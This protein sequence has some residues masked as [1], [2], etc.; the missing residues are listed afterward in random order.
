MHVK[1]LIIA[2]ALMLASCGGC[3]TEGAKIIDEGSGDANEQ[4]L[5]PLREGY[6]QAL[7]YIGSVGARHTLRAKRERFG[8]EVYPFARPGKI[9]GTA[10]QRPNE[11]ATMTF[12]SKGVDGI[13]DHGHLR[14][15][16][17]PELLVPDTVRVGMK[18]TSRDGEREFEVIDRVVRPTSFGVLPVWTIRIFD[19]RQDKLIFGDQLQLGQWFDV[20]FVEGY[21]PDKY[22]GDFRGTPSDQVAYTIVPMEDR[23]TP[24]SKNSIPLEPLDGDIDA[25]ILIENMHAIET[26]PG[27]YELR[28]HGVGFGFMN[29]GGGVDGGFLFAGWSLAGKAYD[30]SSRTLSESESKFSHGL[31]ALADVNGEYS[32]ILTEGEMPRPVQDNCGANGTSNCYFQ[33]VGVLRS[34]D[35]VVDQI[36]VRPGYPLQP[37]LFLRRKANEERYIGD[38]FGAFGTSSVIVS[39]DDPSGGHTLIGARRD[40]LLVS[41]NWDETSIAAVSGQTEGTYGAVTKLDGR[42]FFDV[43]P[44]GRLARLKVEDGLI[45]RVVIGDLEVPEGHFVE[46]ALVIEDHILVLTNTGY[47]GSD[48]MID[49]SIPGYVRLEP[50]IRP[51]LGT[52]HF[53]TAKV[54]S[55]TTRG[56]HAAASVWVAP[57]QADM[58]V[59]WDPAFGEG[60]LEGWKLGGYPATAVRVGPR[61]E[62]VLLIRGPE[63]RGDR[64]SEGAYR[65]EG[66]IPGAGKV[67]I[68]VSTTW[69]DSGQRSW[70]SRS[71]Y[72]NGATT[73]EDGF[74]LS[75]GGRTGANGAPAAGFIADKGFQL[76]VSLS[77]EHTQFYQTGSEQCG[78]FTELVIQPD[79]TCCVRD[80]FELTDTCHS[81]DEEA[82]FVRD[83]AILALDEQ[84]GALVII[85]GSERV[86]VEQSEILDE[87]TVWR[88]D[89]LCG[90]TMGVAGCLRG[91]EFEPF[92]GLDGALL[93]A[94][95]R[96]ESDAFVYDVLGAGEALARFDLEDMTVE[97]VPLDMLE[98]EAVPDER[99]SLEQSLQIDGGFALLYKN[100]WETDKRMILVRG[101]V[102]E[103]LDR[104]ELSLIG[105]DAKLWVEE[106]MLVWI[107]SIARD[108]IVTNRLDALRI[109]IP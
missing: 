34:D 49:D 58:L 95:P 23:P 13:L 6:T 48:A 57:Q 4:T 46:G 9:G 30:A 66:E 61:D 100:N 65:V 2:I 44:D 70:L 1:I 47:T 106:D 69:A 38:I 56:E 42:D 24:A 107:W 52:H 33:G 86:D 71:Y 31:G 10:G 73:Y 50:S 55:E 72:A 83:G 37:G 41:A 32:G 92:I 68:G 97:H 25:S 22:V 87:V 67:M 27:I 29:P 80:G 79:R 105:E 59:C 93:G 94:V 108:N 28:M 77:P 15:T 78:R 16:Y 88:G 19:S 102:I 60:S 5:W 7:I 103:L 20:E 91:G 63:S 82:V 101:D 51:N 84:T 104:P 64:S 11:P 98:D 53:F 12:L 75:R 17:K 8:E 14:Q 74:Y 39:V 36:L 3:R 85:R 62:C 96:L 81:P 26:S 99:W 90:V 54:P 40:G 109:P 76:P 89:T 45:E 21:G 18:W 35:G 43:S